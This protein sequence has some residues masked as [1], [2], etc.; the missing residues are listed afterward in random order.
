MH[1]THKRRPNILTAD[2]KGNANMKVC[3]NADM[4]ESFGRYSIGAD[5]ELMPLVTAANIA[6]GMHAGDP[7]VMTTTIG[8]A[9]QHG[10]GIGAHPGFNDIWG[11]GRRQIA[12]EP[13]DIEYLVTYQI[14]A[15][16]ALAESQGAR[17]VHVKP[18]GALN[19]IA[20]SDADVA[21]A[22]ARGVRAADRDLV[23]FANCLSEMTRTGEAAG[24][25]VAHEAYVDRLYDE[26][27]KML[28]RRLPN[29]VI[30]EADVAA[31]H[32]LRMVT[33]QAITTVGGTKLPTPIDTLCIHGD[34]PTAVSL[35]VASREALTAAGVEIVPVLDRLA[36]A[37]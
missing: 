36:E 11:F 23:L 7:S 31:E 3:L 32:V 21:G 27:G 24:L 10:T 22:V 33:E 14:G 34:E 9:L 1:W 28:S 13:R 30:R 18:H 16:R 26:S 35:A 2:I 8:L 6:C 5:A 19:N 4:G 37:A 25:R 29:A 20:H 17:I 15:L 12:M